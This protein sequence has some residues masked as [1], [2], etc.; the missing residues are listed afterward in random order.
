[1]KFSLAQCTDGAFVE[2]VAAQLMVGVIPV[3]EFIAGYVPKKVALKA[4]E[5]AAQEDE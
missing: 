5:E 1:M 4:A 3:S 2:Q